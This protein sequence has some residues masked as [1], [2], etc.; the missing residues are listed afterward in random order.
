MSHNAA[1]F[2]REL[3]ALRLYIILQ[4][5]AMIYLQEE[6]KDHSYNSAEPQLTLSDEEA[7]AGY[8]G[9]TQDNF[10]VFKPG[11]DVNFR[12]VGW[13]WATV[14]FLKSKQTVT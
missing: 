3:F 5:V 12:T 9:G 14:I 6:K 2:S 11:G 4:L 10:E 13:I 7:T 8:V 1:S